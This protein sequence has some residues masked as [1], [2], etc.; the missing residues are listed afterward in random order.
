VAT[1]ESGTPLI[2]EKEFGRGRVVLVNTSADP[3]WGTLVIRPLFLPLAHRLCRLLAGRV[4]ETADHALGETVP[5]PRPVGE[6]APPEVTDPRGEVKRPVPEDARG[7]ALIYGP[8]ALPGVYHVRGATDDDTFSFA[9]NP[10]PAESDLA[11]MPVEALRDHFGAERF[12]RIRNATGLAGE[13]RRSR[14][15]RPLWPARLVAALALLLFETFFANRV[16]KAR[17]ARAGEEEE[18]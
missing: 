16:A 1:L 12:R 4:E 15:G 5:I 7:G 10:D 14:E 11:R 9:A 17:A 8:L 6:A 18:S 13:L 3:G 2:A